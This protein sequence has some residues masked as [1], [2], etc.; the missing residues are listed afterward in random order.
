MARGGVKE[1]TS[2]QPLGRADF[3]RRLTTREA[4]DLRLRSRQ[5]QPRDAQR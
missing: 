2:E 1:G 3:G 5:S 4:C